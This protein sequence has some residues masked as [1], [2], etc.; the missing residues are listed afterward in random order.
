MWLFL[1]TPNRSGWPTCIFNYQWYVKHI[2]ILIYIL[3]ETDENNWLFINRHNLSQSFKNFTV[4]E[5][6]AVKEYAKEHGIRPALRHFDISQAAVH[7]WVNK[8]FSDDNHRKCEIDHLPKLS[9][10]CG[11]YTYEEGLD[12]VILAHVLLYT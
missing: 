8:D 11:P 4:S 7:N 12:F 5:K 2:L 1:V 9:R 10:S 3:E 6:L